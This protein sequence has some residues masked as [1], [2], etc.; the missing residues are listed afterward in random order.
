MRLGRIVA[1]LEGEAMTENAI[2]A[3]AFAD[4]ASGLVPA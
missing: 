1:E 4:E 2:L 3:A